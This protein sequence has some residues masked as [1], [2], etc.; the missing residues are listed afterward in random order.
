MSTARDRYSRK[1][2]T[3]PRDIRRHEHGR[4][5]TADFFDS[6]A[7]ATPRTAEL[8][9]FIMRNFICTGSASPVAPT[10]FDCDQCGVANDPDGTV[11]NYSRAGLYLG[12]YCDSCISGYAV[13]P[14][15]VPGA[16][17]YRSSR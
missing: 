14:Y 11:N 16:I 13:T 17:H 15:R 6:S 2:Y 3:A 5:D 1:A 9:L 4:A 7:V 8:T 10:S 12:R